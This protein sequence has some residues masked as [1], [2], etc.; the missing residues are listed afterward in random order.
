MARVAARIGP[1]RDHGERRLPRLYPYRNAG[2]CSPGS[3]GK[4]AFFRSFPSAAWASPGIS[5]APWCFSRLTKRASSPARRFRL[6]VDD[7]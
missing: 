2:R 3:D 5:R 1:F 4:G 7:I 6:M